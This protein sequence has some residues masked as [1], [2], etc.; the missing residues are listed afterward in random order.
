MG[1]RRGVVLVAVAL[2]VCVAAP[3]TADASGSVRVRTRGFETPRLEADARTFGPGD[4]I[5]AWRVVDHA[6]TLLRSQPASSSRL[7]AISSSRSRSSPGLPGG[8]IRQTV[9]G[10]TPNRRHRISFWATAAM[11]PAT[12]DVRWDGVLLRSVDVAASDH[13]YRFDRYGVAVRPSR[14]SAEL[15]L[16][17]VPAPG[18]P[19]IDACRCGRR[20]VRGRRRTRARHSLRHS[21]ARIA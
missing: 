15:C 1:R 10:L 3:A 5:G 8:G 2:V 11:E 17:G 21:S 6:V 14:A 18:P 7:K 4:R 13:P 20:D 16:H 12:I 9:Q 19:G